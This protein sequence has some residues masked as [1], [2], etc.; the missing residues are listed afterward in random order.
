MPD[1]FASLDRDSRRLYAGMLWNCAL[2]GVTMTLIGASLPRLIR[3]FDWSYTVSG[4]VMAASAVGYLLTSLVAG[5]VVHRLGSQRVMVWGLAVEALGLLLFARTP[6]PLVNMLLSFSVGVGQGC[7]EVVTNY[8]VIGLEKPGE[9]RLMNLAHASFCVGGVLGPLGVGAYM[10]L[11]DSAGFDW[12][13]LF[14]VIGV[15]AAL[16][17]FMFTRLR[18]RDQAAASAE[19]GRASGGR[20][21]RWLLVVFSLML[22]FYVSGEIGFSNWVS[23]YF[24]KLRGATE[25]LGALMVSVLWLGLLGGRLAF[26]FWFRS[27]RQDLAVLALAVFAGLSVV[28]VHSAPGL[29]L[30]VPA[31]L[32][33]GLGFSAIYP[34]VMSQVGHWLP[35]PKA[36]G[37][38]AT[39]GGV[40]SLFF[41]LL[42]GYLGEVVDIGVSIL[43]CSAASGIVAILGIGV[44]VAVR[45]ARSP[46]GAAGEG[47]NRE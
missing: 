37:I 29:A 40:G 28:I 39:G 33:T 21:A 13:L 24:V 12:R 18:F 11:A 26:S 31:V 32:L 25:A 9:S 7:V 43:I 38:A 15:L 22:L 23:E 1:S 2:F 36:V 8:A 41:P 30:A 47:R 17:T 4:V 20:R 42:M 16:A 34:M 5:F 44:V 3:A 27:E 35:S 14:P 6:S 19:R 10:S 45:R 46:T